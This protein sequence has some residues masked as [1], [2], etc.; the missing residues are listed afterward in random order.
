MCLDAITNIFTVEE[1]KICFFKHQWRIYGGR[2]G[3]APP[4]PPGVQILSISCSFWENLA[5]SYVG[6]PLG[7]WRP[8][9]GEILDPPLNMAIL[10]M[11]YLKVHAVFESNELREVKT[12]SFFK[13]SQCRSRMCSSVVDTRFS[14]RERAPTY[15]SGHFPPETTWTSVLF[16][17]P[18]I[19]T[20]G[21]VCPGI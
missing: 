3:R 17:G 15:Y 6:A 20:S 12:T 16:M 13:R 21:D 8:L 4:P 5:N 1:N 19:W 7:S 2:K 10:E 18:L 11:R 9:P 14:R